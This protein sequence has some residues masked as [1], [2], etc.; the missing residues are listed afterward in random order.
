[1]GSPLMIGC[2]IRDMNQTTKDIFCNKEIIRINQDAVCRQPEKL[3]GTETNEDLVLYFKQMENGDIAIG[4]FNLSGERAVARLNLDEIGLPF[5]TGKTLECR[6]V[7]SGESFRVT[8]ST[9][10]RELEPFGC[11]VLRG[12]VISL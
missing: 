10:I 11:E 4:L 7:W 6:E 3:V 9:I 8:N 5:S 2:D 1:M 12:K